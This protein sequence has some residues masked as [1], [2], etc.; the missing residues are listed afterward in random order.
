MKKTFI[1]IMMMAG[2]ALS[3]NANTMGPVDPEFEAW[4]Y[5][6]VAAGEMTAVEAEEMIVAAMNGD[7]GVSTCAI[8][9][10]NNNKNGKKNN[11]GGGTYIPEEEIPLSLTPTTG[12]GKYKNKNK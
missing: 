5:M 6:Q 2:C 3:A 8:A 12:N 1:A 9:N 11:G 4:V 10:P 7:F